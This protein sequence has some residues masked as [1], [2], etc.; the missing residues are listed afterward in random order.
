VC[1]CLAACMPRWKTEIHR[2][3][4]QW[5]TS[6][7]YRGLNHAIKA[8]LFPCDAAKRALKWDLPANSCARDAS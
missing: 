7:C 1:H 6:G 5:H 4:K 3:A 8:V 2:A